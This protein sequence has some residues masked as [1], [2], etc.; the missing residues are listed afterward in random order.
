MHCLSWPPCCYC[1]G[2]SAHHKAT[3]QQ[4]FSAG[5][6]KGLEQS[7]VD[8]L[9]DIILLFHCSFKKNT[10]IIQVFSRFFD[11]F[12]HLSTVY[13][14][15][16]VL[17]TQCTDCL[18]LYQLNELVPCPEEFKHVLSNTTHVLHSFYFTH[19]RTIDL[20]TGQNDNSWDQRS[21]RSMLRT[22]SLNI[23]HTL[24]SN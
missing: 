4:C 2:C 15:Y 20:P 10:F 1:F 21:D 6:R 16:T 13:L 9:D 7:S 18:Y 3:N 22:L 5:W 14:S 12:M 24:E 19:L 17:L 11:I 8:T 23:I